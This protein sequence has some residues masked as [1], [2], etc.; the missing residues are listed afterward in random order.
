MEMFSF[1]LTF[2]YHGVLA[3]LLSSTVVALLTFC[4]T[5][6]QFHHD[7]KRDA[8]SREGQEPPCLP[9][10]LPSIGH[11]LRLGNLHGL[12]EDVL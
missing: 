11:S 2:L 10:S 3:I 7:L 1:D 12:I 6:L 8:K 4:I 5:S 9:Y